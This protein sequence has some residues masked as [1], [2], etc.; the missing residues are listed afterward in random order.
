MSDIAVSAVSV[1][2]QRF[3]YIFFFYRNVFNEKTVASSTPVE[4]VDKI[5]HQRSKVAVNKVLVQ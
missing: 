4:V 5:Y 2:R 1:G 3:F